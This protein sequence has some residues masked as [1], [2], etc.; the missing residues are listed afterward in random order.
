MKK[1]IFLIIGNI[2]AFTVLAFPSFSKLSA[3]TGLITNPLKDATISAFIETILAAVIEVG[4]VVVTGSI[5]YAGFK[6]VTAGGN[7]SKIKAAHQ[8]ILWTI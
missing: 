1:K 2:M 5:I 7:S 3:E 4:I 8:A 6:Y